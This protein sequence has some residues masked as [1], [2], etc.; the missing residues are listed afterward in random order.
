MSRKF[1]LA[2]V[3][4]ARK[5]QEDAARTAVRRARASAEAAQERHRDHEQ[6]LATRRLPSGA[7]AAA[8]VAAQA[9]LH[10]L[11]ADVAAAAA[12]SEE[13]TYAVQERMAALTDAAARHRSVRKLAERHADTVRDADTAASQ[14]AIDE[15]AT[16]GHRRIAGDGAR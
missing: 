2:S 7:S 11:A 6:A 4:R 16:E 8:Y 5:A 14:R 12:L 15:M 1:R 9:S 13:A 10:A 3:L